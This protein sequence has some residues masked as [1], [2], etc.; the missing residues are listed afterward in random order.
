MTKPYLDSS[1]QV[2]AAWLSHRKNAAHSGTPGNTLI[3]QSVET[4]IAPLV[5]EALK[6]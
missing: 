2:G 4:R 1:C 6:P 3:P 5:W